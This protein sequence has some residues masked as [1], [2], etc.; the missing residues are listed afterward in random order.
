[1]PERECPNGDDTTSERPRRR[2]RRAVHPGTGPEPLVDRRLVES[3]E[4]RAQRGEDGH[5]GGTPDRSDD[6]RF[7]RDVPPHWS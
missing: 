3:G 7:L 6:E 5:D 1:M 2:H 4:D